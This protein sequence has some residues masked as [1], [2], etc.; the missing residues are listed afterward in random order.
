MPFF[1]KDLTQHCSHSHLQF[2]PCKYAWERCC[3]R[4]SLMSSSS[5]VPAEPL[6]PVLAIA[7]EAAILL[8]DAESVVVHPWW[9]K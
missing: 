9:D 8:L 4:S 6:I 1:S 7:V 2:L 5:Q 3:V